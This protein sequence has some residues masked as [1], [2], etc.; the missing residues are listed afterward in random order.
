MFNTLLIVK[1]YLID[2]L[3]IKGV[4]FP[5]S[6]VFDSVVLFRLKARLMY[7]QSRPFHCTCRSIRML[8]KLG[9]QSQLR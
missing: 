4:I 5:E 7:L 6:C 2:D 9:D 8:S 3:G 1:K